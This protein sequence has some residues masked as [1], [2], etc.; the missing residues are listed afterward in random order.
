MMKPQRFDPRAA[1]GAFLAAFV[2]LGCWQV[3]PG[4]GGSGGTGG[5][6][7]AAGNLEGTDIQVCAGACQKLVTC[8]A[9]LDV[10]ACKSDCIATQNASLVSCFRGVSATCDALASC[11]LD[12]VCLGSGAPQ[13]SSS[14]SGAGT[15]LVQCGGDPSQTCPCDCALT[16]SPGVASAYYNLLVCAS[17]HC[18][19]ECGSSGDPTSCDSCLGTSCNA[20][21]QACP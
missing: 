14:C 11:T 3:T 6:G 18:S 5:A 20:E 10:D 12:A 7:G 8:G 13:G 19:Y 4:T 17:I 2:V 1:I 15:C 9:E 21:A 16:A